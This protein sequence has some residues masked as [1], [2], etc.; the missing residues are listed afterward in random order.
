MTPNA[1]KNWRKRLGLSQKEA[2]EVLGLKRRVVQY[3]EKGERDGENVT[4]PKAVR[5][6]CWALLQGVTDYQGAL[7]GEAVNT[8]K[9]GTVKDALKTAP[10]EAKKTKPKT[11]D[12]GGAAE[13]EEPDERDP[14]NQEPSDRDD[15]SE[16]GEEAIPLRQAVGSEG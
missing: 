11:P 3:Y 13:A 7:Q 10:K 9:G 2:A 1:F 4:I 14:E 15:T 6:A 12:L 5:L 8:V 16:G